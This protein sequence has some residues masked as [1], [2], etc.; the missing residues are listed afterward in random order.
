MLFF[1]L[2]E[3][4]PPIPRQV[5][6]DV[7]RLVGW[8]NMVELL[9]LSGAKGMARLTMLCGLCPLL[10]GPGPSDGLAPGSEQVD[11]QAALP[12]KS[13]PGGSSSLEGE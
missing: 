8:R 6:A 11:G 3:L 12:L 2:W 13:V 5:R 10:L 4:G 7:T 1:M 9:A